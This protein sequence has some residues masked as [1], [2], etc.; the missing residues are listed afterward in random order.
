MPKAKRK[1]GN[2][3]GNGNGNSKILISYIESMGKQIGGLSGQLSDICEKI[4]GTDEAIDTLK[5]GQKDLYNKINNI[6]VPNIKPLQ[7]QLNNQF[8]ILRKWC[9]WLSVAIL[10]ILVATGLIS[11]S[12]KLTSIWAKIQGG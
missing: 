8:R 11:I 12:D 4:G 10:L 5:D 7:E 3:N 9:F 2:G 6:V 1:N